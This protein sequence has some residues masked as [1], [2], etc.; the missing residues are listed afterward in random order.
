MDT[1]SIIQCNLSIITHCISSYV[2]CQLLRDEMKEN[3]SKNK[4]NKQK[5]TNTK[6]INPNNNNNK[7]NNEEQNN[8]LDLT[9]L[10]GK[11]GK[12]CCMEYEYCVS[13]CLDP[14]KVIDYPIPR[15]LSYSIYRLSFINYEYLYIYYSPSFCLY[16]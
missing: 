12:V 15:S 6:N 13:C 10:G 8:I 2:G 3:S 7:N 5:N 9:Q 11:N 1:N 16:I 14:Q 4:N